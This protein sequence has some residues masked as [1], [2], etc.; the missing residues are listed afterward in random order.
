MVVPGSLGWLAQMEATGLLIEVQEPPTPAYAF[1]HA[2][3]REAVEGSV[4]AL[5]RAELHRRVGETLASSVAAGARDP[6]LAGAAA[7]HLEAAGLRSDA[8]AQA[9]EAATHAVHLRPSVLLRS[10]SRRPFVLPK[11]SECG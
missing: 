2:L 8:A 7:D 1:R 10:A 5:A 3:I 11:T 9:G 6:A 4:G